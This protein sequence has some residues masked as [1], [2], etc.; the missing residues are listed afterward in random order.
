VQDENNEKMLLEKLKEYNGSISSIEARALL[1]YNDG[2]KNYG[3]Q[4]VIAVQQNGERIRLDLSDFVFKK[5]VLTLV[6]NNDQVTALLHMKK[7]GYH[8]SYDSMSIEELSGLKLRKEI[9]LPALM[10]KVFVDTHNTTLIS[11]DSKTLIMESDIVREVVTFDAE[12]LPRSV[13]YEIFGDAYIM[14][15]VSFTA[16]EDNV[17]PEKLILKTLNRQLKATYKDVRVNGYIDDGMFIIDEK[18]LSG[19]T[20]EYL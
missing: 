18:T 13:E 17:F 19:Y 8:M 14:N 11:P 12:W 15:F 2:D 7:K 9:L 10:G 1:M 5:P 4:A 16:L 3:F 20:I 6:K